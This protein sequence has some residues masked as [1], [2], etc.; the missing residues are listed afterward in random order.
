MVAT[1][2]CDFLQALAAS[3]ELGLLFLIR[4][5]FGLC[6]QLNPDREGSRALSALHLL[7][8]DLGTGC[9]HIPKHRWSRR[10]PEDCA[11]KEIGR[12]ITWIF[13]NSSQRQ[14]PKLTHAC[15]FL[16]PSIHN[17]TSVM[18]LQESLCPYEF[19]WSSHFS[20]FISTLDITALFTAFGRVH[21]CG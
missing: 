3:N 16:G 10:I 12:E 20:S 18:E 11:V 15:G 2:G 21:H 4:R 8:R 6:Y 5:C 13:S 9:P 7:G 1:G 17:S 19:L 14:S